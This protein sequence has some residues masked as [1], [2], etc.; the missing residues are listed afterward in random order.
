[1]LFGKY[2]PSGKLPVTWPC[3]ATP[4]A[5][6][7]SDFNPTGPTPPGDQPK[8]FDQ[9][10]GTN[11]GHGSGY[12]PLYPF[13]FGLSYTTFTTSGLSVAGPARRDVIASFTVANTAAARASTSSRCTCSV[14]STP[15]GS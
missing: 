3:D 15:A 7:L 12:N 11:S 9:F 5:L 4:P 6:E 1:M 14:R 2:N 8:F 10:P 13:G